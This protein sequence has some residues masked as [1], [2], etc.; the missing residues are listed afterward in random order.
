MIKI[1]INSNY[2]PGYVS[3]G[4]RFC[5]R[6]TPSVLIVGTSDCILFSQKSFTAIPIALKTKNQ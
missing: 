4:L 3:L 2:G 5:G 1:A 6:L